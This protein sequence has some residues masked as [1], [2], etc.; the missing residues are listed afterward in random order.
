MKNNL[1]GTTFKDMQFGNVTK[2]LYETNAKFEIGNNKAKAT[3]GEINGGNEGDKEYT[4]K[5]T[6]NASDVMGNQ[7]YFCFDKRGV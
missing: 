3:S 6:S 7:L 4:I 1:D 2:Q 5:R